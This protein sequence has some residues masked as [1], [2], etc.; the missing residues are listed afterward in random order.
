M[1]SMK[2]VAIVFLYYF[3]GSVQCNNCR[4][5]IKGNGYIF[6]QFFDKKLKMKTNEIVLETV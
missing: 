1:Q 3:F 2:I 6:V 4:N 5:L